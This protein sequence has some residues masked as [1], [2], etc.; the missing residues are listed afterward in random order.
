MGKHAILLTGATGYVG[1]RLLRALEALG[2][3]VHCVAR[4]PGYL[5]S[6]VTESTKVFEGDVLD[7]AS[8]R[9]AFEGIDVAYYLVHSMGAAS[10]FEEQEQ[11]GARN[12]SEAALEANVKRII[13]LGGLGNENERLSPHLSSRHEVG[14]ILRESGVPT[15]EF[16]ASIVIGSGSLSFEMI[17]SLTEHLPVMIMPRWVSVFAQPIGIQDMIEYLISALDVPLKESIVVEIGGADQISYRDLMKEY[18]RQRNLK[19]LMISVPV[20]TPRLSSLWLGLVTPLYARVGRKLIES[21]VHPTVV[22]NNVAHELFDLRPR[23]AGDAICAAL[24]NEDRKFAETRWS[25]SLSASGTIPAFGGQQVGGR[26]VDFRERRVDASAATTFQ[27]IESIGGKNGWFAY[28]FLW[29]LRG[30]LDLLV[31]G[32]G[33]RRSRPVNRELR[34]GDALDF[35]RVESLERPKR[36]RLIAEMKIPGRAWLE[37]SVEPSGS[38]SIVTQ[39]AIFDPTGLWG[40]MYWYCVYPLHALVFRGMINSIADRAVRLAR[41]NLA[42][43]VS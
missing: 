20:L 31:G 36:I 7:K 30:L 12:F 10:G 23:G 32:V 29:K 4:R 27:V 2:Q 18:A 8:L 14:R 37:F 19:R 38:G 33:M 3:T 43:A 6:R 1:G 34:A 11:L 5:S 40:R 13:Y 26:L 22:T 25:D 21:I 24:E 17:R 16:R 41:V 39:T 15:L 35:W 28:N 9:A 42:E